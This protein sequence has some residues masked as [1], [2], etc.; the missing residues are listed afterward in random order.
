MIRV[1]YQ[2]FKYVLICIFRYLILYYV[3]KCS[4]F[5]EDGFCWWF[6]KE[7]V[8]LDILFYFPKDDFLNVCGN[9][10]WLYFIFQNH[11]CFSLSMLF[12]T[13]L[14]KYCLKGNSIY[15]ILYTCC[16][17]NWSSPSCWKY[18]LE[19]QVEVTGDYNWRNSWG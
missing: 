3:D 14:L 8:E 5:F 11:Y 9:S 17:V 19:K 2:S 16:R 4:F 12:S 18:I 7:V 1:P 10:E 6:F 13:T 15:L